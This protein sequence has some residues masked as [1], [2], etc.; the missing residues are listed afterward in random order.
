MWCL[1][2]R[3]GKLTTEMSRG[4][5]SR[6]SQIDHSEGFEIAG[7]GKILGPQQVTSRRNHTSSIADIT[8]V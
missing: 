1:T 3:A 5:P 7:V 6:T 2:E 8:A 4:Q